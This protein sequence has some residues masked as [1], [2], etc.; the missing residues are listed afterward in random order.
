[1]SKQFDL[2]QFSRLYNLEY[3]VE[4]GCGLCS[5]FRLVEFKMNYDSIRLLRMGRKGK[6]A[7]KY[8]DKSSQYC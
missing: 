5:N 1:M 8:G 6:N 2:L 7:R 3:A 4:P